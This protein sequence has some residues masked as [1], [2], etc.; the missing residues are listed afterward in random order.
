VLGLY[1]YAGGGYALVGLRMLS[2][3]VCDKVYGGWDGMSSVLPRLC[4]VIFIC[5]GIGVRL[6]RGKVDIA[7]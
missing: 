3:G 1:L 6:L 4:L 2:L 5:R 7:Q